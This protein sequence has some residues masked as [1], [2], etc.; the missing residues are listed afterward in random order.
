V[1]NND[2][3]WDNWGLFVL[4]FHMSEQVEI[5]LKAGLTVR[6]LK[7]P[8][9]SHTRTSGGALGCRSGGKSAHTGNS[10]RLKQ[11]TRVT[12]LHWLDNYTGTKKWSCLLQLYEFIT[13]HNYNV[14]CFRLDLRKQ[15][16]FHLKQ[17]NTG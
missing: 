17:P 4:G 1:A 12:L 16:G 5:V 9:I 15:I 3:K 7:F 13:F 8:G 6:T 10:A 14:T 2:T 11:L